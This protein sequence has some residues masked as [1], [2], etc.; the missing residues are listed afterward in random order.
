MAL[1]HQEPDR[2]PLD[3]GAMCISTIQMPAY[4][5]MLRYLN[6]EEKPVVLQVTGNSADVSE[7]VRRRLGLDC[8][9]VRMKS[10]PYAGYLKPE[11]GNIMDEWGVEWKK[12]N[13]ASGIFYPYRHPVT[14]SFSLNDIDKVFHFPDFTHPSRIEG[15]R[16]RTKRL[17][18][19]TDY[20]LVA[21][22]LFSFNQRAADLIGMENYFCELLLDEVKIGHLLE[23]VCQTNIDGIRLCLQQI[24]EF[25]EVVSLADD[26]GNQFAPMIAPETYHNV[27]K[28]FHK[29]MIQEIRKHTGAKILMHNDGSI[30]PFIPDIID[31]GFDILNPLQTSAAGMDAAFIKKEFGKDLSFWGGIDAQNVMAFGDAAAVEREVK[32]KLD[33]LAPGGGYVCGNIHN[34]TYEIRPE[35]IVKLF[36]TA[37]EYGVYHK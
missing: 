27:I 37:R 7:Q 31:A 20:A 8:V 12:S 25:V 29:L 23:R 26:L 24:G 33:I 19:E 3:L 28:P 16:E 9:G 5:N 34:I 13:D 30:V 2:V 6:L 14:T 11:T 17:Y 10:V 32:T 22:I 36:D 15:L 21:D 18:E 4:V 35:N 1:N